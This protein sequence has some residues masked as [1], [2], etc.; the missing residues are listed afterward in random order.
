MNK[1][2]QFHCIIE[3]PLL[4][5]YQRSGVLRCFPPEGSKVAHRIDKERTARAV[6]FA[7]ST[8]FLLVVRFF[9]QCSILSFVL[10]FHFRPCIPVPVTRHQ[11]SR[12]WRHL[13]GNSYSKLYTDSYLFLLFVTTS[14]G[15][16]PLAPGASLFALGQCLP[17]KQKPAIC[18]VWPEPLAS[19]SQRQLTQLAEF[20][21]FSIEK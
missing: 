7:P 21:T 6:L 8:P 20:A 11:L 9:V 18:V 10:P 16:P 19:M 5:G 1:L 15:L 3:G 2:H 14:R 4:H 17:L 12:R 13:T